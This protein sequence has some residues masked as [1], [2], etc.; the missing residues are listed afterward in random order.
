MRRIRPARLRRRARVRPAA[1]R[2]QRRLQPQ[3]PVTPACCRRAVS[4]HSPIGSPMSAGFSTARTRTFIPRLHP[5]R[6]PRY[7]RSG[8]LPP[9][10]E[11]PREDDLG[12]TAGNPAGARQ[13]ALHSAHGGAA[14]SRPASSWREQ[15]VKQKNRL[16]ALELHRHDRRCRP[17]PT[18]RHLR[19]LK[20]GRESPAWQTSRTSSR[21][22][23]RPTR[24]SG[25]KISTSTSR[26]NTPARAA[27]PR[28]SP[29]A[30]S[31]RRA[32]W[33]ANGWLGR[34][35]YLAG[36]RTRENGYGRPGL[37][38]RALRQHRRPAAG[39]P[40]RLRAARLRRQPVATTEGSYTEIVSR[41]CTSRTTSRRT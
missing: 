11:R 34:T 8:K 23:S 9:D 41:A 13:R 19:H 31:W 2:L 27:R 36:V 14:S 30:M 26:T 7:H 1:D 35:G 10:R 16:A 25:G 21:S 38:P 37:G 18:A 40:R 15:T 20:T 39:R 29:P 32:G 22:A 17:I 6:G 3:S 12:T 4:M 33:G 5:D 28:R 24:R